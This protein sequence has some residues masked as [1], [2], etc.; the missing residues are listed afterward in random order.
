[1]ELFFY[2][3]HLIGI[4]ICIIGMGL[5]SLFFIYIF[6]LSLLFLVDILGGGK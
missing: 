4:T 6:I 1:M 5:V 2:I 3:T